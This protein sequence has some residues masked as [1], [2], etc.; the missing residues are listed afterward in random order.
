MTVLLICKS[1]LGTRK[2]ICCQAEPCRLLNLGADD[3]QKGTSKMSMDGWWIVQTTVLPVRTV[4]LTVLM[5]IAAARASNPDVGSCTSAEFWS[6]HGNP[7]R[8]SKC[9]CT[10]WSYFQGNSQF[11]RM[12][13]NHHWRSASYLQR[14]SYQRSLRLTGSFAGL[15]Y[16]GIASCLMLKCSDGQPLFQWCI[17]IGNFA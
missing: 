3:L 15:V 8:M 6:K 4:F 10:S 7:C 16:N 13:G 11:L 14:Y 1:N 12:P 17:L 2:S 5:T 9:P